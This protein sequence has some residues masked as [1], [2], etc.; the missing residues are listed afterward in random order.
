[1]VPGF[2]KELAKLWHFFDDVTKHCKFLF[3]LKME[4]HFGI[5][6]KRCWFLHW[7]HR[8]SI[9]KMYMWLWRHDPFLWRINLPPINICRTGQKSNEFAES[10]KEYNN[11]PLGLL[12]SSIKLV[13]PKTIIVYLVPVS[14]YLHRHTHY[15]AQNSERANRSKRI[16][17]RNC[18]FCSPQI[19]NIK[20]SG[21]GVGRKRVVGSCSGFRKE[22]TALW[23]RRLW[24]L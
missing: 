3:D 9:Y 7:I 12:Q 24:H 21:W 11:H 19:S 13:R 17:I 4:N 2:A 22:Y 16:A 23:I 14:G 18:L 1:M 5:T 10:R 15:V 6:K 8:I 20:L